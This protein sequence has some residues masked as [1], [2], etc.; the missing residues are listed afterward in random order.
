M[1]KN[2]FCFLRGEKKISCHKVASV[3]S[4]NLNSRYLQNRDYEPNSAALY[5]KQSKYYF[6]QYKSVIDIP[7]H[8]SSSQSVR[9]KNIQKTGSLSNF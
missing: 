6:V 3:T 1:K 2:S 4:K 8:F 5:C 7:R 9:D